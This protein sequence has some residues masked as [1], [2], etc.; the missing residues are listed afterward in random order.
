MVIQY[1]IVADLSVD[2]FKS[3]G[4]YMIGNIQTTSGQPI[5][6]IVHLI[7]QKIQKQ[8]LGDHKRSYHQDKLT[9]PS[10]KTGN[11]LCLWVGSNDHPLRMCYGLLDDLEA[12]HLRTG[13]KT[14]NS[15][16]KEKLVSTFCS[17]FF[18]L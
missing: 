6:K 10:T 14:L 11:F 18:A 2:P 9:F 8:N 1:V 12:H 3:I 7:V 15:Y 5:Q 4:E 13:A 16:I 17:T